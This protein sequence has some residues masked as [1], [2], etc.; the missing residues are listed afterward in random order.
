MQIANSHSWIRGGSSSKGP[1]QANLKLKVATHQNP[2]LFAEAMKSY[3]GAQEMNTKD[4]AWRD[5]NCLDQQPKKIE[6]ASKDEN[7]TLCP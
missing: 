1:N 5:I 4:C 6:L 3:V 7:N 2:K